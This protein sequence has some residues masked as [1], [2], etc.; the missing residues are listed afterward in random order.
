MVPPL[1]SRTIGYLT[2]ASETWV[3]AAG[4]SLE[5]LLLIDCQ[6]ADNSSAVKG[7][8][9]AKILPLALVRCY[10][11]KIQVNVNEYNK[12]ATLLE[13]MLWLMPTKDYYVKID[14]DTMIVPANFHHFVRALPQ[15]PV[16]PIYF[17]SD[18]ISTQIPF[19]RGCLLSSQSWRA[20]AKNLSGLPVS[21]P[22]RGFV[23]YAQGNAEGFSKPALQLAVRSNC[24]RVIGRLPCQDG[25]CIH[26]KE[27]ATIG[28]CMHA[29]GVPLTNC[30]CFHAWG[31]C[32][33]YEPA[34]CLDHT[35]GARLCRFPITIHKL[36]VLDW[37]R[38]WWRWINERG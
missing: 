24:L 23:T 12:L 14:P 9:S 8:A 36:K 35:N 15:S 26:Q 17:G 21:Q 5:L 6:N 30:K 31:P 20:T 32:N 13:E 19:C 27:D 25:L 11:G 38:N 33:I 22:R 10:T 2:C 16:S 18:E 7:L 29:Y 34:S 28:L 3:D 4:P 1:H 37:Y